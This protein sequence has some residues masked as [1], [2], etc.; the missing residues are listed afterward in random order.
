MLINNATNIIIKNNQLS[1][2]IIEYKKHHDIYNVGNPDP[3]L[4]QAQQCGR[5]KPFS[6]ITIF[7]LVLQ[8]Q[9]MY[10]RTIK[11]AA[12]IR[13]YSKRLYFMTKMN[14]N[15]VCIFIF[16]FL[17]AVLLYCIKVVYVFPKLRGYGANSHKRVKISKWQANKWCAF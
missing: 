15:K 5:V 17:S 13:F 10:K 16:I 1:T 9:C 12:N 6:G 8:W 4:G 14:E 11:K 2:Q 7:L 3:G